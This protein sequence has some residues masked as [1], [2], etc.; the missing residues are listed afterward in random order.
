MEASF[1]DDE[2]AACHNEQ[3]KPAGIPRYV[4]SPAQ[5]HVAASRE[6][7]SPGSPTAAPPRAAPPH[8]TTHRPRVQPHPQCTQDGPCTCSAMCRRLKV[9][10]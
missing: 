5:P 8:N 3:P 7:F 4:V 9:L 1:D 10:P 6:A 2:P